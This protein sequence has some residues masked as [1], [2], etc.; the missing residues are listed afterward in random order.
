M[1]RSGYQASSGEGFGC[2]LWAAASGLGGT[3]KLELD[4]SLVVR[5]FVRIS[6]GLRFIF[7]RGGDDGI[8]S[9]RK[10][11]SPRK[12]LGP[13]CDFLSGSTAWY[14]SVLFE[15]RR[16]MADHGKVAVRVDEEASLLQRVKLA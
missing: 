6:C 3:I 2:C 14:L 1:R 10:C 5:L 16:R 13:V 9:R 11:G 7:V 12:P 8:P 15:S 4:V